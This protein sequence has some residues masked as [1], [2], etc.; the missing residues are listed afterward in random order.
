MKALVSVNRALQYLWE[1]AFRIFTPN[2]DEVPAIGVQP[3]TGE[4]NTKVLKE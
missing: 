3:Y 1:G 4:G 2:R